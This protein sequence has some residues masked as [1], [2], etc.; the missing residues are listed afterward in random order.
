MVALS[1]VV[2]STGGVW[3]GWSAAAAESPGLVLVSSPVVP[4]VGTALC[5][6]VRGFLALRQG[7]PW[8]GGVLPLVLA[9]SVLFV[10]A[11]R[12]IFLRPGGV[13]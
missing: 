6:L 9:G 8:L 13:E 12:F 11:V 2:V 7:G 3:S 4:G 1:V 10:A 5:L